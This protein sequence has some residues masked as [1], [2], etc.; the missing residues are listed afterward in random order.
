MKSNF[1][2]TKSIVWWYAA[3]VEIANG[4]DFSKSIFFYNNLALQ[5]HGF[6]FESTH[7]WLATEVLMHITY[8]AVYEK[9]TVEYFA[10]ADKVLNKNITVH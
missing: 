9:I 3:C 7:N 1:S 4:S 8:E 10:W 5:E 6:D 2:L